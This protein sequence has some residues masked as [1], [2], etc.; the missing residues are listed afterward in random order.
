M[1]GVLTTG[2]VSSK[3]GS[4][5][6]IKA[7]ASKQLNLGT[8][9]QLYKWPTS[10]GGAND[11]LKTD[12]SNNLS[13]VSILTLRPTTHVRNWTYA[14]VTGSAAFG[15]A[16]KT[17]TS[18]NF[19]G[20]SAGDGFNTASICVIIQSLSSGGGTATVTVRN[21]GNGSG[22]VNPYTI[23]ITGTIPISGTY[24]KLT[25][26]VVANSGNLPSSSSI[27]EVTGSSGAS[28]QSFAINNLILP[29]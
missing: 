13:F 12:G 11:I 3:T 5:L 7:S 19:A 15:G 29:N 25:N 6:I 24:A 22:V 27:F 16:A 23:I 4:D 26:I 18:F 9:G 21:T 10:A 8:Q 1:S 17:L 2:A 20:T 14:S 28:S